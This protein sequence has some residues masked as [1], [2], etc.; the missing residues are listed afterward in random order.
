MQKYYLC[1]SLSQCILIPKQVSAR[2]WFSPQAN[3]K[4]CFRFQNC[5]HKCFSISF[6][7]WQE[8]L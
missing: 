2:P 6:S 5:L 1:G 3:W 7:K 8:D 4:I